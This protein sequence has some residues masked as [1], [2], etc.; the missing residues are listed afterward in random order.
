MTALTEGPDESLASAVG[1]AVGE[2]GDRYDVPV[3][4]SLDDSVSVPSLT[5][6]PSGS[7][8]SGAGPVSSRSTTAAR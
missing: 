6:G 1:R 5:T 7:W 8:S 2:V 4:L 3:H